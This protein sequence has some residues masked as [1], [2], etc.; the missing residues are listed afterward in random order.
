MEEKKSPDGQVDTSIT[1]SRQRSN[2]AAKRTLLA[3]Q[4]T[5]MAWTRTAVSLISFG[6]TIYTFFHN[7]GNKEAAQRPFGAVHFAMT[8]IA[9]GLA[10]LLL[11]SIQ[12]LRDVK[13]L[14]EEYGEQPK[15]F[16]LWLAALIFLLGLL[17]FV[18]VTFRL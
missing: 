1:L 12:H 2:L 18:V 3:H 16:A 11:A 9:T 7:F 4:R 15:D 13:A 6:F 10:S 17:G 14:E 8:M 5:L